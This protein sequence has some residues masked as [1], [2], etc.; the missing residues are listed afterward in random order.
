VKS[1]VIGSVTN[2]IG[3]EEDIDESRRECR[4][5]IR[6]IGW[7][8]VVALWQEVGLRPDR[9]AKQWFYVTQTLWVRERAAG[10]LRD[11]RCA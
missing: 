7:R 8:A 5:R 4:W 3:R 6:R 10:P 1:G 2:V 11:G 9:Y